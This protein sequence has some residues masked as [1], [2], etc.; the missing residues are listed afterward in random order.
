MIREPE[1]SC[2][3]LTEY[4]D[5]GCGLFPSCLSCPLPRCRYDEQVE[6]KRPAKSLRND[7]IMAQRESGDMSVA[8]LADIFGVSKRTIQRI[9]RRSSSEQHF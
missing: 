7:E 1:T 5:E 9:I 2:D 3:T 8:E 4:R 6:G